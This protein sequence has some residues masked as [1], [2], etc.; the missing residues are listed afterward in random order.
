[1]P[2]PAVKPWLPRLRVRLGGL[3]RNTLSTTF[4]LVLRAGL[5]AA[6]LVVLSRWLGAEGYGL[7]AG[8][9]AAAILLAPLSNWGMGYVFTERLEHA[10]TQ[11]GALWRAVLRQAVSN[12]LLL[13]VLAVAASVA[14]LSV[15]VSIAD[16]LLL[17]LAELLAV[18][19]V[20]VATQA[21]LALNRSGL[22][23]TI[24]CVV[25][26]LRLA[27]AL[28]LLA[29]DV[30]S[31]VHAIAITH[32]LGSIAGT[33]LALLLAGRIAGRRAPGHAVP[34][35]RALFHD[36]AP[37]AASAL[38]GGA[39]FEVD[40]VLILQ[41][42]GAGVAGPYTAA[43][44]VVLVLVLPV[45]ALLGNALPRLFAA[46]R[47]G[48]GTALLKRVVVA[49]LGYGALAALGALAVSPLLPLLFGPGYADS[50]RYMAGLSAW[51]PLFALHLCG[52]TALVAAGRKRMRLAVE[53]AG[54]ALVVLLNLLL[55]PRF[56]AV[57]AI[58]ALL[59]A[60]MAMA[61]ACWWLLARHHRVA[62]R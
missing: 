28:A 14:F 18:P 29:S 40:K 27:G 13:V 43:F 32:C 51:V 49:A 26:A 10:P 56:G 25:P 1:M 4:G 11:R 59:S 55:L 7:F 37:Y 30:T 57:G 16:M 45:T 5:Q 58:A 54:L 62:A 15:R 19:L 38:A 42:L 53:S 47:L 52:A 31:S 8:S 36:G 48:K 61:G 34:G 46:E 12:G 6:Y 23:A 33:A 22:A 35:W 44:R 39:Y 3:G 50:A 24:T 2:S 60:E 21:L 20:H 9:V 41:L 17:A